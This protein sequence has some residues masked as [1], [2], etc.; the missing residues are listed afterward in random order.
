MRR[1]ASSLLFAALLNL[2][3]LAQN[4][5]TSA[6]HQENDTGLKAYATYDG[7]RENINLSNGNLN[8]NIP[9]LNLPG[10]NGHDLN[11]TLQYDSKNWTI[12]TVDTVEVIYYH[13]KREWRW[14][15]VALG[16]RLNVPYLVVN[17]SNGFTTVNGQQ[18][19]YGSAVVTMPAGGKHLFRNHL[20]CPGY[21]Q[22]EVDTDDSAAARM[23]INTSTT[24]H[25][26]EVT[27]KSGTKLIFP[28]H[29]N[30]TWDGMAKRIYDA[31]GNYI[32]IN[33]PVDGSGNPIPGGIASIVDTVGRTVT[34]QNNGS[35][36]QVLY[37]NSNGEDKAITLTL[38]DT[39]IKPPFQ[40]PISCLHQSCEPRI[41][42]SKPQMTLK[43]LQEVSFP[44]TT[45]GYT[46]KYTFEYE[47]GNLD[48]NGYSQNYG[49]LNKITYATGGYTQYTYGPILDYDY[50]PDL[51]DSRQVATRTLCVAAGSCN[52]TTYTP[53]FNSINNSRMDVIEPGRWTRYDFSMG[54]GPMDVQGYAS[55]ELLRKVY[56]SGSSTPLRTVETIYSDAIPRQWSQ[57]TEI[58][59]TNDTGQLARRT[60]AYDSYTAQIV[61][62]YGDGQLYAA[63]NVTR[64]LDNVTELIEY[65]FDGTPA[66]KATATF[67]GVNPVNSV[68][69]R[70]TTPHIMNRKTADATYGWEGG[71]WVLKAQSRYTYDGTAHSSAGAIKHIPTTYPA[72]MT[73]SERW[74][75]T[76]GAWLPTDNT[77]DNAGNL[78]TTKDPG[79]DGLEVNRH[80]TTF[81]YSDNWQ[82]TTC[83]GSE[84][85]AYLR[86]VTN[87][88]GHVTT[89]SYKSCT[90]AVATKT[91]PNNQT[92]TFAYD[93]LDRIDLISHPDGGAK[94]YIYP[95]LNTVEV[96][97]KRTSTDWTDAWHR[98]DGLGRISQKAVAVPSPWNWVLT[99]TCYDSMGRVSKKTYPV[100][101]SGGF[102]SSPCTNLVGDSFTYDSL[103]RPLTTTHPDNN[104]TQTSYNGQW[105]TVIDQAGK[106]RWLMHDALGRL[107]QVN[108][109]DPVSGAWGPGT[110]YWY[111]ALNN[112]KTVI[113][114]GSRQ[115]DFTYNS[116]SQL[117]TAQNPESGTITYTYDND[118]NVATKV[119]PKPNQTGSQTVTTTFAYDALHRLTDKTFND[120]STQNS[121]YIY[122]A[123]TFWGVTIE[124][125]VGRRIAA[126]AAQGTIGSIASYDAMGRPKKTWECTPGAPGCRV[127]EYTYNVDGTP[128]SMI[129]PQGRVLN[130]GYDIAGRLNDVKYHQYG[131]S[132]PDYHYWQVPDT[133]AGNPGYHPNGVTRYQV[134]GNG[135]T[136]TISLN[137]RLQVSQVHASGTQQWMNRWY[138]YTDAAQP[139]NNGNVMYI[140][141]WTPGYH[142]TS[143]SQYFAYDKL[144]RITAAK[145]GPFSQPG[146]GRWS[147]T[148]EIDA[149]GNLKQFGTFP[150]VIP[151]DAKNQLYDSAYPA[152]YVYDAAGN[153]TS[154][155]DGLSIKNY[156]YDGENRITT[157]AGFTYTYDADGKRIKKTDGAT[158]T[159]Y[160]YGGSADVFTE[161]TGTAQT[162]YIFA[163]G[164]RVAKA[165]GVAS[166]SGTEYY[167][168]DHLGSARLMTDA[169]GNVVANSE[170]TYLPYGQQLETATGTNH[171]KF[172]GKERDG[173]SG[174]DYFGARY[175]GS[176]MGR[177]M[178]P[179]WSAAPTPVP[180]ADFNDP[181]TLNLY[182]YV[183]NRPI[184]NVDADGHQVANKDKVELPP[185]PKPPPLPKNV[186][187]L[188]AP[189]KQFKSPVAA[190]KAA[191]KAVNPR[192]IRE[193]REYAGRAV[194]NANGTY[195]ATGPFPGTRDSSNP[196]PVPEGTVNAARYHTHGSND[197]G[198]RNEEFSS[199]DKNNARREGVPS[200]LATPSGTVKLFDPKTGNVT[201]LK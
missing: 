73:K 131:G 53:T 123:T 151:A 196:G 130:F 116:L 182:G 24:P 28:K 125:P 104:Y 179:D 13:W 145:E 198:Y 99:A 149:W 10:R 93:L 70:A 27:D 119:A 94:D 143:R 159:Y 72:L 37:K 139:A 66:R 111:D 126:T 115:R 107:V 102:D 168:G 16:W 169:S 108:E 157:T 87:H 31:A 192:S 97:N 65:H 79:K 98:F 85:K 11:L 138:Y 75:N 69:Y 89:T 112:L 45:Q 184:T 74:R 120:A 67:L 158:A 76:D 188:N 36:M 185:A 59:T 106:P 81:N 3:T 39:K 170:A 176:T 6:P 156:T 161:F 38:A 60:M 63:Q 17:W 41:V 171:Y 82:Q 5:T 91:D 127:F 167:H 33:Q 162:D 7:N 109:P 42:V 129:Y 30:G 201:P 62:D 144:N 117:L 114:N 180:Y 90:G 190:A 187:Y 118:G 21:E 147:Q 121:S 100:H 43:T 23:K 64:L 191:A 88:L 181:Q 197:P 166:T 20:G 146:V 124:N 9:L 163:G 56:P 19:C 83:A 174:L 32:E 8:I 25:Q 47:L 153:M 15:S 54:S 26:L 52:T 58:K 80:I 177:W 18:V 101:S 164:K 61:P 40:K 152:R 183:G 1:F 50:G 134:L 77:Y 195:T 57:P 194:Q 154:F 148:Y 193:G 22:T 46:P 105:T 199:A 29:P 48:A 68:N 141:D 172:T 132:Y 135:V 122:D 14:P 186:P 113:Q 34:I 136:N 44:T 84:T 2:I 142:D 71:A 96:K 86:S 95:D 128:A 103:D 200:I 189:G 165:P 49:E 35:N 51:G 133:L 55:Q 92:T 110:G 140:E 12:Q 150:F 137:N 173:E 155:W 178:T 160:Y 4:V 78:L 175:Y